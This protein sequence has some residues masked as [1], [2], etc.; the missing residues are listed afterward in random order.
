MIDVYC[1]SGSGHSEEV[2]AYCAARL[3]GRVIGLAE[4]GACEADR[5]LVVF[6]VYC[7]NLPPPVASFLRRAKIERTAFVAAYGG[8]SFGRVLNDAQRLFSGKAVAGA[9]VPTEHAF[10]RDGFRFDGAPLEPLLQKLAGEGGEIVFPETPKHLFSDF[11][12]AWR[13][14]VGAKLVRDEKCNGCNVCAKVCPM[15]AM[16]R[17]RANGACIRCLR[18]VRA[19]PEEALSVRLSFVLGRYLRRRR[20]SDTVVYV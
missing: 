15:H 13:S 3:G 10:T 18:C 9:Y 5:A 17:G 7:E 2:A 6:P 8:I 19:C 14:R 4:A 11:A 12:P 16:D 20:R 1:F